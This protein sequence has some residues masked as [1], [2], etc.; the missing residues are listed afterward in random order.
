MVPYGAPLAGLPDYS[1]WRVT[2]DRQSCRPDECFWVMEMMSAVSWQVE[3][4]SVG[5][6]R[7]PVTTAKVTLR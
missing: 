7:L 5:D 3:T 2:Y 1:R 6:T 4:V